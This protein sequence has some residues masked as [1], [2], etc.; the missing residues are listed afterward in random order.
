[1]LPRYGMIINSSANISYDLLRW[2]HLSLMEHC[3]CLI[4]FHPQKTL[5][6]SCFPLE[7]RKLPL[8]MSSVLSVIGVT[9]GRAVTGH[10]LCTGSPTLAVCMCLWSAPQGWGLLQSAQCGSLSK[11]S[12]WGTGGHEWGSGDCFMWSSGHL[13]QLILLLI[14]LCVCFLFLQQWLRTVGIIIV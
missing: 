5:R 4:L 13:C 7:L 1:M 6:K 10:H 3:V 8:R 2:L 14:G 12:G 9:E 11:L